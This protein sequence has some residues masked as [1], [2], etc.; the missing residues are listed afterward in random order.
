[1]TKVSLQFGVLVAGLKRL[2][3]SLLLFSAACSPISA[4]LDLN[5]EYRPFNSNQPANPYGLV[6]LD[7]FDPGD[8]FRHTRWGNYQHQGS[9]SF[10]NRRVELGFTKLT[11]GPFSYKNK[12]LVLSSSLTVLNRLALPD[13][14]PALA[15]AIWTPPLG[16][17]DGSVEFDLPEGYSDVYLFRKLHFEVKNALTNELAPYRSVSEE[18]ENLIVVIHGWNPSSSSNSFSAN[19]LG[20]MSASI[21]DA[22]NQSGAAPSW[23]LSQYDWEEDADT[24]ASFRLLNLNGGFLNA[25]EVAHI[26]HQHGKH[27]GELL[28]AKSPNLRK[29]HFL[30]H[31]AGTWAARS[32]AVYLLDHMPEV[33]VQVTLLDP[34]I[35]SKTGLDTHLNEAKINALASHPDHAR[36]FYLENVFAEDLDGAAGLLNWLLDVNSDSGPV[37]FGSEPYRATSGYF[38]PSVSDSR[39]GQLRVD[40]SIG[41]TPPVAQAQ[42]YDT[43]DGPLDFY[44]DTIQKSENPSGSYPG[45]AKPEFNLE[46]VGWKASMFMNEPLVP[47]LDSLSGDVQPGDPIQ[48]IG[49][50]SLRRGAVEP[51]HTIT[52][53]WFKDGS[54]DP[55]P[56][57]NGPVLLIPAATFANSGTYKVEAT[58]RGLSNRSNAA[59]ISVA[60][61]APIILLQPQSQTGQVGEAVQFTVFAGGAAPFSYQWRENGIDL[62]GQTGD[63]LSFTNLTMADA[64]RTFS[65]RVSNGDGSVVSANAVLTMETLGPSSD[66]YEPN[67]TSVQATVLPI[68]Q[69]IASKIFTPTDVDWFKVAV[70]TPG[71]ITVTLNV[72][73]GS[74]YDLEL[75]G[76]DG[77]W[78]A[79]SYNEPGLTE[80]MMFD[81]LSVGS[82]YVRVSGFPSG[83]GSFNETQNYTLRYNIDWAAVTDTLGVVS[84]GSQVIPAELYESRFSQ[85]AA[86]GK[87]NLAIQA[88]GQVVGWG[89]NQNGES[90]VPAGLA[91][92]TSVAAGLS[93]SLALKS[94]GSVAA[95]GDSGYNKTIV[96]A[97]LGSVVQVVAGAT[98]S[99]ALKSDGTVVAWGDDSSGKANVPAGLGSVVQVAAGVA[100]S[101]A[102]KSD[103]TIV[104]WGGNG[105]GQI[106]IPTGLTHVVQVAAGGYHNLALKSDGTVVAWGYNGNG[107]TSVP[108]G[109]NGV[110]QVV[111]GANH[112]LAL[113]SDMTVVAWGKNSTGQTNVVSGLDDI[114]QIAAGEN[115]SLALKKDGRLIAW[116][117]K[118]DAA[119]VSPNDLRGVVQIDAGASN[120]VALKSDGTVYAWG[121]YS[122]TVPLGLSGVEQL[123]VGGEHSLA[124]LVGGSVVAWG[125]TEDLRT[126]LPSGLNNAVNIAP[127]GTHSLALK[128]DGTVLAWGRNTSGQ[129]SVPQNLPGIIQVSAGGFHSLAINNDGEVFAWGGNTDGQCTVPTGLGDVVR[130]IGGYYHTLALKGDGT[131]VAWGNNGYGQSDVPSGLDDVVEVAASKLGSVA[132]RSDGTVHYWGLNDKG[133]GSVPPNLS[134]VYKIGAGYEHTLALCEVDDFTSTDSPISVVHP[135][136]T[137][138]PLGM[139]AT[140]HAGAVS[141]QPLNYQ[142]QR[143]G[144]DIPGATSSSLSLTNVTAADNGSLYR[145]RI[146]NSHGE[147]FTNSAS[148]VVVHQNYR[149]VT[150]QSGPNGS[151]SPNITESIPSGSSRSFTATPA[152]STYQVNVWRVNGSI[153][154]TGG[155]AFTLSNITEDSTVSVSFRPKPRLTPSAAPNGSISPSSIQYVTTGQNATFTATPLSGF[156]V[157]RWLVNGVLAQ[158]GGNSFTLSN[159]T[160]NASVRV[161]FWLNPVVTAFAAF[162]GSISPQGGVSV[163][164]GS[165][166]LFQAYPDFGY[167]V[168]EWFLN[169]SVLQSGGDFLT[170]ENISSN[171]TLMLTFE[172]I[173]SIVT[174]SA[175]AN[176]TIFPSE[177]QSMTYWDSLV[178]QAQP[179]E[180]YEVDQWLVNGEVVQEGG[181]D[182]VL[183]APQ[184]DQSIQVTFKA[185]PRPVVVTAEASGI[186]SYSVR[187]EG[188]V[189]HQGYGAYVEFEYGT[190]AEYGQT[191]YLISNENIEG[192]ETV[193]VVAQT[194]ALQPNTTY[195]YRIYASNEHGDSYSED[196]TFTTGRQV[197]VSTLAGSE[198]GEWG[199]RDGIASQARFNA[200]SAVAVGADGTVYIA[201]S[202]N[203]I[204]RKLSPTGVVTTLA[205]G[206]PWGPQ[207]ADGNGFQA[208]FSTMQG[209]AVGADGSVYV[210]DTGN[211]VI[212]KISPFGQVTTLAGSAGVSGA[213]DGTGDQARF[214]MPVGIAVDEN[215]MVFVADT[216]NHCIR[217][218]TSEGVVSTLA[219]EAG[220]PGSGDGT[221]VEGHFGFPRGLALDG[222]GFLYVADSANHTIRKVSVNGTVITL[223]GEAGRSGML[224]GYGPAARFSHPRGIAVDGEGVLTVTDDSPVIRRVSP[225]GEVSF[226]AGQMDF[227]IQQLDGPG[228]TA[229]FLSPAGVAADGVGRTYVVD[230]Q[231]HTIRRIS[232]RPLIRASSVNELT[233]TMAVVGTAIHGNA[234]PVVGYLDY[235]LTPALGTSIPLDL[236]EASGNTEEPVEVE[237]QGLNP[238]TSYY[239]RFRAS[240]LSGE[241]QSVLSTFTTIHPESRMLAVT[242]WAGQPPAWG[243]QDGVGSG[244]T[245]AAPYGAAFDASGVLFVTDANNS[246]VRKITSERVVSTWATNLG[247]LT[248]ICVAPDAN[249]LVADFWNHSIWRISP[250]GQAA[251]LT[252]GMGGSLGGYQDG[253]VADAL[254]YNPGGI[255]SDSQGNLYVA[256]QGN[257]VIRRISNSGMVS[258]YAGVAGDPGHADGSATAARFHLPSGLAMASDGTLYVSEVGNH[259][260]RK[261]LPDGTVSTI[262]GIP[263][264]PGSVDG[265]G[266]SARFTEPR[267][268]CLGPDGSIYVADSGN[269]IIRRIFPS[270]LVKTLAGRAHTEGWEDGRG[271]DARF[272]Y[273]TGIAMDTNGNLYVVDNWAGSIRQIRQVVDVTVQVAV[274]DAS[275]GSISGGGTVESGTEVTV[276]AQAFEGYLFVNWQ[277]GGQVVATT[278]SYSFTAS[279]NR[280][281]VAHFAPRPF[282]T[283]QLSHFSSAEMDNGSISGWD[284]E[285]Q[286]DGI[287]N[288][289]KFL[290]NIDPSR[291]MTA[292]DRAALPRLLLTQAVGGTPS[293]IGFSFRLNSLLNF[294]DF[295][296]IKSAT[297]AAGSWQAAVPASIDI[298]GTDPETGDEIVRVMID[299]Q[300][301]S[302]QFIQLVPVAP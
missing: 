17:E 210:A 215:G 203:R 60:V 46:R 170:M 212:R 2:G 201:D 86:G 63:T 18:T 42:Y 55:I 148:L 127:G 44:K 284:A 276:A 198:N 190:N 39:Q 97:G 258:T 30:A 227:G 217:K 183:V 171:A 22:I 220:V 257:H 216:G 116:G 288:S 231:A 285:P 289:T 274:H 245:F 293:Q 301:Q 197:T 101:L 13:V 128:S 243:S 8:S 193:R 100:H 195:H 25:T 271:P 221:G 300:G 279:S 244:A 280:S 38:W 302:R 88:N 166:L 90:K 95:W 246:S 62:P 272:V 79:G 96:P 98:H 76:P 283:W 181:G 67:D 126:T 57:Q 32:A 133:Q 174:P 184:S 28:T 91:G 194:L 263:G 81:A 66:N 264:Q 295:G 23:H 122:D 94:D 180:G 70:T 186:G 105:S 43:H 34:F 256:D 176:G 103:G 161:E 41:G 84:W 200:P 270:G 164:L 267:G 21:R 168:L 185:L 14:E 224:S 286:G 265:P 153:V 107:E 82:Y 146:W 234:S 237:L 252:G 299:V 27:L 278:P 111:A 130:L 58:Y 154:Q 232:A 233:E 121:D 225:S 253:P 159:V 136:R 187:L 93:H 291:P 250:L 106:N 236:S 228:Q 7:D 115:H 157:N 29:V 54:D 141:L 110:V 65:V 104:A 134:H 114:V 50:A 99:L 48:L 249:V 12:D 137:V 71:T 92:V 143:N 179:N 40:W 172:P 51:G 45:L 132:L 241:E 89:S 74:D 235:G 120:S 188:T 207:Y 6:D 150:S 242:T 262:A 266:L 1:V 73:A 20:V 102:L 75:Y 77:F 206:G 118:L 177:S 155:E 131:V 78:K 26:A 162:G 281:L 260:I 226:L 156:S 151:I 160:A 223:A 290:C 80:I 37:G 167:R 16:N 61:G 209:I 158:N 52:Y 296:V 68:S 277:E 108:A 49:T 31:S 140:F 163:E 129:C 59:A 230:D 112:N 214:N 282:R 259:T 191:A 149:T 294:D 53:Q 109:L 35:P 173:L 33:S 56:G 178:F 9:E 208:G 192:T 297:L 3:C 144:I 261:I 135:M 5:W 165:D 298:V 219:G 189:N 4:A 255:V 113:K 11:Q 117:S 269:A 83:N 182:Y 238:G 239:Y 222:D 169:G 211:N 248:G 72:P 204:I 213:T 125:T 273:P 275:M 87:H 10:G 47:D 85:L 36:I 145:A 199:H 254:F 19:S 240:N 124:I 24:G 229:F 138:A 196:R 15:D 64:G 142:W 69:T 147:V 205:G 251:R 119:G 123:A 152:N 139:S 247:Y 268:L 202:N 287:P 292:Q 175:G 218:I